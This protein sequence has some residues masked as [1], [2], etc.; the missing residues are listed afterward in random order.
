MT[1]A[2]IKADDAMEQ[3]HLIFGHRGARYGIAVGAVREIVWLP[4]LSAIEEAPPYIVGIFNL[5][6][7]IVPVIDL[8]LRFGHLRQP[9]VVSDRV[10]VIDAGPTPFGIIVNELHDVL[11]IAAAAI[12]AAGHDQRRSHF[13]RAEARLEQGLVMLLDVARLIDDDAAPGSAPLASPCGSCFAALSHSDAQ[14]VRQRTLDLA[15]QVQSTLRSSLMPFAIVALGNEW[16]GLDLALVREFSRLRCAT[17]LPCCPPHIVGNMNLRGD[18]LT[19]VDIR[20]ALG[21]PMTDTADQV[22]VLRIGAVVMGLP[23]TT[24]VDVVHLAPSDIKPAPVA[25]GAAGAA[26]CKGVASVG[27]HA[28]ALL[29]LEKML[30]ARVLQVAATS[31]ESQQ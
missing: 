1:S 11:P 3:T 8:G 29:D 23:A 30:A 7:S 18:I 9:C 6:G 26:Y 25:S 14:L 2:G 4:E 5:R 19:L 27:G 10:I 20:P 13:V 15:Q 12:D 22:V 31:N 16:F 28:V 24:I 17:P 21:M